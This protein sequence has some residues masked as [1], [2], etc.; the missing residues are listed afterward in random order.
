MAVSIIEL[1]IIAFIIV[2]LL[3]GVYYYELYVMRRDLFML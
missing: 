3:L 2:A 1:K